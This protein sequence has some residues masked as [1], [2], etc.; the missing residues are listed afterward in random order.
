ME[1]YSTQRKLS[2][3]SVTHQLLRNIETYVIDK[4]P[5]IIPSPQGRRN[6]EGNTTLMVTHPNGT[7]HFTP[8]GKFTQPQ[9]DNDTESIALEFK[10]HDGQPVD[11]RQAIVITIRLS[12]SSGDSDLAIALKAD[13]AREK[14]LALEQGLLEK[15]DEY[16]NS[17]RLTYPNEVTPI[18]VFIGGFLAFLFALMVENPV[19]KIGCIIL[20]AA[21]VYL[22]MHSFMKG[23]CSFDSRRQRIMNTIFKWTVSIVIIFIIVSIATPLRKTLWG[24]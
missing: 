17:N 22:V 2:S 12:S 16:R 11:E 13:A 6:L 24:F 3:Y 4:M 9:F 21:A 14:G 15:L 18:F 10:Y 1:V 23:Y 19:L 8:S 20:F 5:A 7:D